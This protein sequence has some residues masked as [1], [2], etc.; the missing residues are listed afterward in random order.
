MGLLLKV[1]HW[2]RNIK[3]SPERGVEQGTASAKTS[4]ITTIT[5]QLLPGQVASS[6]SR[7]ANHASAPPS[8][9][10]TVSNRHPT[11]NDIDPWT[12]AFEIF[13]E[14]EPNL[15]EDYKKHLKGDAAAGANV[16]DRE[17]VKS[18]ANKLLK[19]REARQWRVPL[20]DN[21]IKI[22]TQVEKL[23]KFL[24]WSDPIVK[25]AVSAQPYAAL[26]WSG[27]SLLLPVRKWPS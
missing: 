20:L 2:S 4:S 16:S 7:S 15:T 5:T 13:K 21:D 24:L 26:A 8:A 6:V 17:W 10:P 18:I 9:L 23:A 3:K 12:P 27:V 25:T 11:S 22:R 14:R 19:D 1:K